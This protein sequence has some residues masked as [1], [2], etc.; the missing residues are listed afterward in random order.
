MKFYVFQYDWLQ[1]ILVWMA[2]IFPVLWQQ[3]AGT[4]YK[5]ILI[6]QYDTTTVVVSTVYFKRTIEEFRIIL[7]T[8]RYEWDRT[9]LGE[10]TLH[11]FTQQEI[12]KILIK[13]HSRLDTYRL[14]RD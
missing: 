2:P 10:M 3:D 12:T 7:D 14:V 6:K 13:E 8:A 11:N 1:Q 5:G 9:W 4:T